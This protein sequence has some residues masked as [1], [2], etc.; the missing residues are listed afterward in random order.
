M[1]IFNEYR[2]AKAESEKSGNPLWKHDAGYY[3]VA[4][5]EDMAAHCEQ[6]GEN[7]QWTEIN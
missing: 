7:D 6:S 4:S 5:V 2:K 3:A 1:K